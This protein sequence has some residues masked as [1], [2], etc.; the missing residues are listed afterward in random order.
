VAEASRKTRRYLQFPV[1][2]S[3][4]RRR[5]HGSI[6]MDERKF[7]GWFFYQ[8]SSPA[9][10]CLLFDKMANKICFEK[11]F[12][13]ER[14]TYECVNGSKKKN[15]LSI[16]SVESMSVWRVGISWKSLEFL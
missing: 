12:G 4:Y 11:L 6:E 7:P 16:R 9:S 5:S 14:L 15:I 10:T 13:K 1:L 3:F 2:S 8:R